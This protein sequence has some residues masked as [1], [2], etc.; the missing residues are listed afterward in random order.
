M[1]IMSGVMNPLQTL[2]GRHEQPVGAEPDADVA[3]VRGGVA[4]GVH[5]PADFD[6]VGAQRGFAAHAVRRAGTCRGRSSEQK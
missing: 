2:F 4:A 1:H 5:A 6:D 3:V